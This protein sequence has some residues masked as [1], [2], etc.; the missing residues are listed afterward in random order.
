MGISAC[1]RTR[2]LQSGLCLCQ[3]LAIN[4]SSESPALDPKRFLRG[5]VALAMATDSSEERKQQ[6]L[7]YKARDTILGMNCRQQA[8][9]QMVRSCCHKDA[10]WMAEV[11][12]KGIPV[13][14]EAAK[15][16]LM[17]CNQDGRALCFA[18]LIARQMDVPL[19][20][21]ATASRFGIALAQ[22]ALAAV[23]LEVRG[24]HICHF[25]L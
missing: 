14:Y 20:R 16:V 7:W 18:G 25:H 4:S 13:G 11:F 1:N 24:S 5:V 8:G 19:V 23:T 21:A 15:G 22:G 10:L 3:C 6:L 9:V 2:A 12:T 17:K